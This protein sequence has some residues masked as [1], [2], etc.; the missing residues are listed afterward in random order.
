MM[1]NLYSAL[2]GCGLVRAKQIQIPTFQNPQRLWLI[3]RRYWLKWAILAA[4]I[5]SSEYAKS[6]SELW[7]FMLCWTLDRGVVFL[8]YFPWL[9]TPLL[10][11]VKRVW[12]IDA[13]TVGAYDLFSCTSLLWIFGICSLTHHATLCGT[14]NFIS[15]LPELQTIMIRSMRRRTR[16]LCRD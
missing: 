4:T 11:S 14:F 1:G 16:R 8:E 15:C 5:Q 13:G 6:M 9:T 3:R 2:C 12:G 7:G 10:I